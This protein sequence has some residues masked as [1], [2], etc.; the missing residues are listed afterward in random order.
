MSSKPGTSDHRHFT[1]DRR[2]NRRDNI[3]EI[4]AVAHL[5]GPYRREAI[6]GMLATALWSL[7]ILVPAFLTKVLIDDGI[8]ND[9]RGVVVGVAV[10][11]AGV[12][13]AMWLLTI[14]QK[15][16]LFDIGYKATVSLQKLLL[17]HLLRL[18]PSYHESHPVG[19]A[20]SKL[21]NDIQAARRII[22]SGLPTMIVNA[23]TALGSLVMMLVLDWDMALVT[24]IVVPVLLVISWVYR[25]LV[26]PLFDDLR[27][28][29]GGVANSANE[30]LGV[31][32][33]VQSYNQESRHRARFSQATSD[34]R[35]AEYRTIVMGSVYFPAT[36]ILSATATGL[37]IIYGGTQVV[38]GN[39]QVGTMVGFFGYLLMF[40]GPISEFSWIFQIYQSGMAALGKVFEV[41]DEETESSEHSNECGLGRGLI[42]LDDVSLEVDGQ[43]LLDRLKVDIAAGSVVAF[44]GDGASGRAEVARVVAGLD[45]PS[46]GRVTYDGI[47]G[48]ALAS[49]TLFDWLGYVSPRTVLFGGSVRENLLLA[50]P[51][52]SDESL[53]AALDEMFGAGFVDGLSRGLD[54]EVGRDG[55]D[56]PA[57]TRQAIVIARAL[58]RKPQVLVLDGA[59]DSLDAGALAR[60]ARARDTILS[61]VTIVAATNQPLIAEYADLVV[62]LKDGRIV[63]HGSP[64][65]L[66]GQG[67]AFADLS[68]S[69]RSGLTLSPSLRRGNSGV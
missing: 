8:G 39:A 33:L 19:I 3:K 23:V 35:D 68:D 36:S 44:V 30:T 61:G 67:G 16:Y 60:L 31:V 56:L 5:L 38:R 13:V 43:P 41:I 55:Q 59:V 50:L 21:T 47:D 52:T 32:G 66:R 53:V 54:T 9:D 6:L 18:P 65:E 17:S 24:L 42:K 57:G 62:V 22:T 26:V 63:E 34:S 2:L 20:V 64:I 48:V 40:L 51:G 25:R 7:L 58:I 37:L 49:A 15:L 10:V 1:K 45:T 69:W 46:S 14:V 27:V 12:V 4:R 28:A 29:I 11:S